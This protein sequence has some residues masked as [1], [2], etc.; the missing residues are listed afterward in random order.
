MLIK[1]NPELQETLKNLSEDPNISPKCRAKSRGLLAKTQS[2][3]QMFQMVVMHKLHSATLTAEQAVYS[4]KKLQ[5]RLQELRSAEEF[6][7]LYDQTEEVPDLRHKDETQQSK[8]KKSAPVICLL[9]LLI[10]VHLHQQE[11]LTI[12][13]NC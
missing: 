1:K 2:L 8:R 9:M 6:Q 4:I 7:R 12:K 5:V 3:R 13:Q 10:Q 11:K